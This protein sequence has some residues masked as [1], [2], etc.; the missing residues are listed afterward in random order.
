MD[1]I[2][3]T[4]VAASVAAAAYTTAKAMGL[5]RRV[6]FWR[7]SKGVSALLAAF[8]AALLKAI[9]SPWPER[10]EIPSKLPD[11][12]LSPVE[13]SPIARSPLIENPIDNPEGYYTDD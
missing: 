8:L 12:F 6:G 4:A 5:I 10:R 11:P 1:I 2:I 3:G 13:K 7:F 9:G